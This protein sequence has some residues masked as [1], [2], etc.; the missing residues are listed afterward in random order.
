VETKS[1]IMIR[2]LMQIEP[3]TTV[4]AKESLKTRVMIIEMDQ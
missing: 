3:T 1:A 4:G 2:D